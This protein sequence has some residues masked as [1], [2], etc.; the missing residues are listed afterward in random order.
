MKQLGGGLKTYD[1]TYK[2]AGLKLDGSTEVTE[3]ILNEQ[4]ATVGKG[5][6]ESKFHWTFVPENNGTRLI[7][8]AE[9]TVPIPVLG[10]LAESIIL[11][12]NEREADTLL[13]NLKSILEANQTGRNRK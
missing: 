7:V 5:G 6:I 12:Q 2:M 4:L 8:M 3:Y 1:W 11:K 13:A 9:Y 10:K